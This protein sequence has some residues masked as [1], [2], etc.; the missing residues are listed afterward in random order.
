MIYLILL[1]LIMFC[2]AVM[3]VCSLN[4]FGQWIEKKYKQ[5]PTKLRKILWKWVE[6]DSWENKYKLADKLESLG[7]PKKIATWL[8][9]DVLV[10]FVDLWHFSKA[11]MMAMVEFMVAK[12]MVESMNLDM[13]V[14]LVTMLLFFIGGSTF[15][16]FYYNLRKIK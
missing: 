3:D 7:L 12:L 11:L 5:K 2:S 6:S 16:F 15:N 4:I 1:V 13:S 14:W 9:K 8:A 10:I